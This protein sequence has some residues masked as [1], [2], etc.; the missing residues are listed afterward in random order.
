[1]DECKSLFESQ[2]R[3]VVFPC[4]HFNCIEISI[5]LLRKNQT[6]IY[7]IN[8]RVWIIPG[9]CDLTAS[10]CFPPSIEFIHII[11]T[12][13]PHLNRIEDKLLHAHSFKNI[14]FLIKTNKSSISENYHSAKRYDVSTY[15][16][17]SL[18]HQNNSSP[19][20]LQYNDQLIYSL[21][22]V[23]I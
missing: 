12:A 8:S 23:Q 11:Q 19:T 1:M 15:T 16:R 3:C 9:Y 21:R 22:Q 7:S 18:F 4:D 17:G 20:T 10:K 2:W 14:D 5:E 6:N 13:H